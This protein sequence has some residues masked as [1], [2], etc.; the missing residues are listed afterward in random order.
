MLRGTSE[1]IAPISGP[2]AAPRTTRTNLQNPGGKSKVPWQELQQQSS[3]ASWTQSFR[4]LTKRTGRVEQAMTR[5]VIRSNSV[6]RSCRRG[7]MRYRENRSRLGQ[8]GC[9][10]NLLIQV[11]EVCPRFRH[12]LNIQFS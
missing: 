6:C 3:D 8:Y 12:F 7:T 11:G 10:Q 4:V 1:P 5:F 9:T 2:M